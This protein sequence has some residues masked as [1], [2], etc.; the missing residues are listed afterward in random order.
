MCIENIDIGGPTLIRGAAKNYDNVTVL[1]NPNQYNSFLKIVEKNNNKIPKSFREN[2]AIVA[3]ENTSYYDGVISNW[4]N[5]N[6]ASFCDEKLSLN[7][8][9]I[10]QLRYGEN[11]HQRA[12]LFELKNPLIKI[13]GKD[14]SFNNIYDLEIAMELAQQFQESS[15]VILKH[16]NPCGV[17]LDKSQHRAFTKALK[18]DKVSAF[19]GII[20]F[21][22]NSPQKLPK[23]LRTYLLKL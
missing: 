12:A 17:A 20:A 16:G 4:F 6:K 23:K 7:F 3:F 19:G 10:S 1:T 2:C 14:L 9:K 21:N 11:P 8:K 15:C 18:C 5:K 13:S 22:K